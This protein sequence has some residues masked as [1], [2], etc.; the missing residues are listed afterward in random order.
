MEATLRYSSRR[1]TKDAETE[2]SG[3]FHD[4]ADEAETRL[5]R[6][7]GS[8]ELLRPH[9]NSPYS[10]FS[11]LGSC[12][13][14]ISRLRLHLFSKNSTSCTW[15]E[16]KILHKQ[17]KNPGG[18]AWTELR[19]SNAVVKLGNLCL[20]CRCN[21]AVTARAH[22]RRDAHLRCV[23]KILQVVGGITPLLKCDDGW[24]LTFCFLQTWVLAFN[25]TNG[26]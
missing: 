26:H 3:R 8:S 4:A 21:Q 6:V 20:L 1:R 25:N 15:N 24:V 12:F 16:P 9:I 18:R 14:P 23:T 13:L 22:L 19:R 2:I 7:S 17:T 11:G 10:E 5:H